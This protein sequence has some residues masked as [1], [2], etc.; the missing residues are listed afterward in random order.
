MT[1][2]GA[3]DVEITLEGEKAT[4]RPTLR[5]AQAISKQSGG[6]IAAVNAVG[7][8]DLETMTAVIALGLNVT[9]PNA[10]NAL[11]EKIYTTGMADLVEPVTTYLTVLANGGKRVDRAGGEGEG[12]PRA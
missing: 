1:S 7:R 2:L 5:A 11:A 4:L 10:L 9:S 12:S 8:F 6:I 3:G